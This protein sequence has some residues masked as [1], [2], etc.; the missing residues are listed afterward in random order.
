MHNTNYVIRFVLIMTALVA[1]LLAFLSTALKGVHDKNEA[2][3]NKRAILGAVADKLD[4]NLSSLSDDDI[5]GIFTSQVEQKVFD[6]K[7]N[8]LTKEQVEALGY[9]GGLAEHVD[10]SKEKKKAEKDRIL[11]WYTYNAK[12]GKKYYILAVRGNGLWD[13]IWGNIAL[14]SDLNTISGVSFD[15]KAETPGLGAEIKDNAA[16]PAMFKGKKV[17]ATDGSYK[18]VDVVKGGVKDPMHQVDAISGATITAVGVGEMMVRGIEY[19]Q[20]VFSAKKG[21]K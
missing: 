15:H 6:M 2:I 10:T 19:Y 21:S 7:G 16:F 20:P 5:A 13:E 4:A 3:Y 1:V 11:P 14:D 9:K 8:E 17:F 18:S 12:D